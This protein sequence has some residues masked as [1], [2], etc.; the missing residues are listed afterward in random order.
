MSDVY[1]ETT[2]NYARGEEQVATPVTI[3]DGRQET[4][5]FD[6]CGFTLMPHHSAVSCWTDEEEVARVHRPEVAEI[7]RRQLG[8]DVTVAYPPL[9]RSP[10]TAESHEDYAPI[11][12][13]HSDFT[14]DYRDMVGNESRPYRDFIKPLLDEAGLTQADVR[15][16]RRVAMLQFWRN[17]GPIHPVH[18]FALCDA[19]TSSREELDFITVEEY[20]GQRLEFQTFYPND[21]RHAAHHQWYTFPSLTADEVIV[22][23]TYDSE[24][25]AQGRPYWTL[26]SAFV[27]PTV[28]DAPPR[29][30]V[31]MRVLCL[32]T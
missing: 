8:C 24:C 29:E 4:L 22:F 31:E 6:R 3:L 14:S 17:I 9:I 20:G 26:H 13:V 5:D 15:A 25:E 2:L 10:K 11:N 21:P 16:A 32:W 27:D 1:C 18:P 19:S 7:A 30:S 28:T 12:F 23:R